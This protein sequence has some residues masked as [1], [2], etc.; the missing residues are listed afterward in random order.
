MG[1]LT[2]FKISQLITF[3]SIN[4][5]T[6]EA[7]HQIV[8]KLLKM[9]K[10]SNLLNRKCLC[11]CQWQSHS[12]TDTL[13]FFFTLKHQTLLKCLFETLKNRV[14]KKQQPKNKQ[15]NSTMYLF[16]GFFSWN[17]CLCYISVTG[18]LFLFC[19]GWVCHVF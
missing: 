10:F 8:T 15:K 18:Y 11:A 16:V 9:S 5:N 7:K 1:F 3:Y 2:F 17:V 19:F 14:D 4:L 12:G 6:T 13:T